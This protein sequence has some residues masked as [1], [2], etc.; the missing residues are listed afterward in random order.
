MS[1]VRAVTEQRRS[2]RAQLNLPVRIRW[3]GPLGQ[4]IELAETLDVSRTGLLFYRT[5]PLAV[6]AKLW[7]TYPFSKEGPAQP[8]TP[9]RVVRVKTTP[10]GG[11]LVAIEFKPLPRPSLVPKTASHRGMER[12]P[13][14][15]PVTI[16]TSGMPW[17]EEA[18]TLD[19][20]DTGLRITTVRL[21]RVGEIVSV[22]LAA[23]RW[24]VAQGEL[25]ARV[26]RVDSVPDSVEHVVALKLEPR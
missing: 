11:Q 12:T 2:T 19:V 17:G 4:S 14:A 23:G 1:T 16:R 10:G 9:G 7:V 24:A 3:Q 21:Y 22:N 5:Q 18:M 13:V 8:E 6:A 15:L 20:S 26:V 25:P